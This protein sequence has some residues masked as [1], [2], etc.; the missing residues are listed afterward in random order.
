M[1]RPG[2]RT[3]AERYNDLFRRE[4]PILLIQFPYPYCKSAWQPVQ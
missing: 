2:Y 1:R 3:L 4:N